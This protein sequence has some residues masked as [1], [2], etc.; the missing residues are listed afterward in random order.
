V[1]GSYVGSSSCY[2]SVHE[3]RW[4][5]GVRDCG[6]TRAGVGREDAL[7]V[8]HVAGVERCQLQARA[9]MEWC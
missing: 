6:H 3:R 4:G 9:E 7:D 1:E 5:N 8:R 2:R